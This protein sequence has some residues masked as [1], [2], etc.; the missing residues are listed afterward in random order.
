MKHDLLFTKLPGDPQAHEGL[1]STGLKY[2][3]E[4]A[5][6]ASGMGMGKA[7]QAHK[8]ALGGGTCHLETVE[9]ASVA[10]ARPDGAGGMS[11]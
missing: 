10:G 9:T 5:V 6:H 11:R 8:W 1:R 2:E 4:S 3:W 7:C